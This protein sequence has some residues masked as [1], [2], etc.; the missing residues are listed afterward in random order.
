MTATMPSTT[1]PSWRVKLRERKACRLNTGLVKQV[2][3][4]VSLY[5]PLSAELARFHSSQ[6]V[7]RWIMGGNQS[8]KSY[9]NMMDLAMVAL[10]VHPYRF[11]SPEG[12]RIWVG[13]ESWEQV[14]DVLWE[15]YLKKFIPPWQILKFVWGQGRVLRK[16]KMRNG[17][18]IEFKAFNQ[19]R[20][21]FQARQIDA[22]YGD[23]Q[24][25]S[26]FE[27]ILSEIQA[28]LMAKR[29]YLSWSMSPIV[30]QVELEARIES[31]PGTD[32]IFQPNLNQNR[33]SQGGYIPDER[34]DQLISEWPEEM[35]A[36][37]V[38][39]R[40]ATYCGSVYR[41]FSRSL[42]RILEKQ[43][44]IE[45]PKYRGIDFGFTNPFV[46]VW[47]AR[48]PDDEWYVYREYYRARTLMPE[49]IEAI[50]RLSGTEQ[51]QATYADPENAEDR[52]L[53]R[54]AGM[55]TLPARKEVARGIETVQSRLKVKPNGRPSLY[56]MSNCTN[57]LREFPLYSYATG[58]VPK[59]LP[60]PGNDHTLDAIRYVI[61]SIE[62]R[63]PPSRVSLPG[64]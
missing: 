64:D 36:P 33:V 51:Y 41:S 42:H 35:H 61:Y 57:T 2:G 38:E 32:G 24:C 63:G 23:E 12:G 14:R 29:G 9:A 60:A 10:K 13:I 15:D 11:V 18:T 49:H 40:F 39:G 20:P 7:F 28:R 4:A 59:D 16:L 6:K 45:W 22:F 37:R 19:G 8:G 47:L 25:L 55:P 34:V 27:G 56:V 58:R 43:L 3:A 31:L 54:D 53:L 44:P 46:C 30:P 17:I 26:D 1:M 52:R 5:R 50:K 48:S 62:H 21:L